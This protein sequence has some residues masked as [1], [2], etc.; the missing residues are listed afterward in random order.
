MSEPRQSR[1]GGGP[2][3][4]TRGRREQKEFYTRQLRCQT[5]HR[6][7]ASHDYNLEEP[8]DPDSDLAHLSPQ[9]NVRPPLGRALGYYL[10]DRG[11]AAAI[12]RVQRVHLHEQ[13]PKPGLIEACMSRLAGKSLLRT[14][15]FTPSSALPANRT[16]WT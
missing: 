9:R 14:V 2:R 4:P 6:V 1:P 8:Q 5:R 10:P 3:M 7:G 12:R 16:R 15:V 13:P 11:R